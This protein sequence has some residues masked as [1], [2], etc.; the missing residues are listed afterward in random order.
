MLATDN[1]TYIEDI[2][3]DDAIVKGVGRDVVGRALGFIGTQFRL[4][5]SVK[6]S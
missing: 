1:R 6:K 4:F 5:P 2:H 3:H